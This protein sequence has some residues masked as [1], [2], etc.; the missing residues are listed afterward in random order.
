MPAPLRRCRMKKLESTAAAAAKARLPL[1]TTAAH[2]RNSAEVNRRLR[3]GNWPHLLPDDG[4]MPALADLFGNNQPCVL[5]IGFGKGKTLLQAAQA[6]PAVNFLG[7]ELFAP[8]LLSA[9]KRA[10]QLELDNLR[11][12]FDDARLLLMRLP[13]E[14]LSGAQL[15]FPDPW[16]KRRQYKRRLLQPEFC[17]LL[18]SRLCLGGLLRIVTD[19]D[20]YA[21]WIQQ[22]AASVP[23]LVG[24][25]EEQ[26]SQELMPP[27]VQTRFASRALAAGRQPTQLW[28][29]AERRP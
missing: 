8:G 28:F 2:Y 13:P 23:G 25:A 17:D 12:V 29:R 5:D 9:C 16:P 14:S 22:C 4:D 15:L 3:E 19:W 26:V 7:V 21:R 18:R 10:G 24:I 11:L 1:R 27:L 6:L 20:D